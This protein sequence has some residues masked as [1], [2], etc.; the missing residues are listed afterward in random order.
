M[1]LF[2][3]QFSILNVDSFFH[4]SGQIERRSKDGTIEV[5]FPDGSVRIVQADGSEKWVL[6]DGTIAET[7]SNGEKILSLPN[8]QREIHT[9]DHKV[10]NSSLN[11]PPFVK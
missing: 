1:N 6:R 8:G 4:Y 9:K 10:N 5:T 3:H 2:K 11:V 7:S